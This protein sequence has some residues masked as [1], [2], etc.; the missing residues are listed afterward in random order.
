MDDQQ[1]SINMK[2]HQS[3]KWFQQLSCDMKL[4]LG[5]GSIFYFETVSSDEKLQCADIVVGAYTVGDV[6]VTVGLIQQQFH[7]LHVA[8]L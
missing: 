6:D 8:V 7:E 5:S 1:Q 2:S 4:C 3:V